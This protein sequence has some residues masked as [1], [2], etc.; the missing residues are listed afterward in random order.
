M[1]NDP[2][3]VTGAQT[4]GSVSR[5]SLRRIAR[6]Q[7]LLLLPGAAL[8]GAAFFY[9]VIL[10]VKTS[11]TDPKLGFGNYTR[12]FSESAAT[13]AL[14]RTMIAA[15]IVSTC[16]ALLAYPYAYMMTLVRPRMRTLMLVVVS[17]PFW[18]SLIARTFAWLVLE[19]RGGLIEHFLSLFGLHVVLLGTTAG[20][21]VA[22]VQIVLVYMV[23]PLYSVMNSIDRRL[24]S[25]A[26]VCGAGR[27]EAFF[28]VYLPLTLPG[29]NAG[30]ALVFLLTLGFYVTPVLLGSSHDALVGQFIG[31]QVYQLYDFPAASAYSVVLLVVMLI[32]LGLLL[33]AVR[34]STG[35][36]ASRG[37]GSQ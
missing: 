12:L 23:F 7:R 33:R 5:H 18:T 17:L 9:P 15:C 11:F 31:F 16:C 29:L 20:V 6:S 37:R 35:A 26:H 36:R 27:A 8:L 3:P 10:L 4:I 25:A 32:M 28:R 30:L 13:S 34:L 2:T 19:G 24:L 14:I 21:V 22:M 1:E